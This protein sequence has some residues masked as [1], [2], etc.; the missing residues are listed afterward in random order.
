MSDESFLC[1]YLGKPRMVHPAACQWHRD[2]ADPECFECERYLLLNG[3]EENA[4]SPQKEVQPV[5]GGIRESGQQGMF[6]RKS[7]F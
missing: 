4:A 3:R 5:Q 7:R 2:E 1:L 6:V